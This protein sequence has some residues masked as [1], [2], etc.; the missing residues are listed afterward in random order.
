MSKKIWILLLTF[1]MIFSMVGC[2]N[3]NKGGS[4]SNTQA[5]GEEI[6]TY[7]DMPYKEVTLAE[8]DEGYYEAL[9]EAEVYN[10]KLIR[11]VPTPFD[12]EVY[13]EYCAIGSYLTQVK[14]GDLGEVVQ[15]K[16]KSAVSIRQS[17]VQTKPVKDCMWYIWGDD[18]PYNTTVTEANFNIKSQDNADFKPFLVPYLL[19]DQTAAKGNMIVIA[20]GGYSLRSNSGEG[21]P[22]AEAYNKL[23]YNCYVLQRRVA[24]YSAEEAWM[25]LQRSIRY[26]RTN[27]ESLGLGGLDCIGATGFSGG[28]ATIMGTI[29]NCYGDI[30]PTIY[31]SNYVADAVDAANSDL[32]VA[33]IMYGPV[34]APSHDKT[35][36]GAVTDNPNLP[37]MFIAAG[38]TDNTGACPDSIVLA[39]SLMDRTTVEL[40]IFAYIGHGFGIGLDTNN[41]KHWIEMA[42]LFISQH[43]DKKSDN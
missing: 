32:D 19:E 16:L 9:Y 24:P 39:Q 35:Y 12:P 38:A 40:H 25:D 5:N 30:Q 27:G 18:T 26:I 17:M 41:S 36:V 42:D 1:V 28:G 15:K 8:G 31:D 37:S 6:A 33:C 14:D 2:N 22:I 34:S 3:A 21:Y 20:G 10:Y 29:E 7:S 13:E 11:N 4:S 43:M 23:G